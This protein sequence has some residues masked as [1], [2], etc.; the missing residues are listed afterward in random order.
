MERSFPDFL[1][2]ESVCAVPDDRMKLKIGGERL[3]T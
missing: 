1:A 3:E 2:E